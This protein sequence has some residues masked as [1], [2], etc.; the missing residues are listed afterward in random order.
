MNSDWSMYPSCTIIWWCTP[1]MGIYLIPKIKFKHHQYSSLLY[2][3]H[4]AP[5]AQRVCKVSLR[6]SMALGFKT[7]F[8]KKEKLWFWYVWVW[9][10]SEGAG[11]GNGKKQQTNNDNSRQPSLTLFSSFLS[12]FLWQMHEDGVVFTGIGIW[13]LKVSDFGFGSVPNFKGGE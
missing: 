11:L 12:L 13:C 9:W 1:F 6:N 3:F 8:D 10:I 7:L 2:H 4:D 5:D